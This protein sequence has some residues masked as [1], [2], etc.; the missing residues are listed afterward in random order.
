MGEIVPNVR[1]RLL[2]VFYGIYRCVWSLGGSTYCRGWSVAGSGCVWCL[3][4]AQCTAA[5]RPCPLLHVLALAYVPVTLSLSLNFY[6]QTTTDHHRQD[7]TSVISAL[8][9]LGVIKPQGDLLSVRRAIN[10]LIEN[11]KRQTE[12]QETI[13]AIGEVCAV[14]GLL[15]GVASNLP[16]AGSLSRD[17]QLQL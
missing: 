13:G 7:G 17:R 1:E 4:L 6:H 3:L 10:Y 5:Q 14:C 12:R 9:E 11:I 8:V 15:G 2:D 16:A